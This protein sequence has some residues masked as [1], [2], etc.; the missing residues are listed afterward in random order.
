[1]KQIWIKY[2]GYLLSFFMAVSL[3][4][5]I[6]DVPPTTASEEPPALSQEVSAPERNVT[7]PVSKIGSSGEMK[8]EPNVSD[9]QPV[10]TVTPEVTREAGSLNE[11]TPLPSPLAEPERTVSTIQTT[12][13][14][15]AS[16]PITTPLPSMGKPLTPEIAAPAL[17]SK[18]VQKSD[19]QEKKEQE[20]A[21][22]TLPEPP[23]VESEQKIEA[24]AQ[25]AE[26][27]KETKKTEKPAPFEEEGIDTLEQDGGNWLLKRQALEKT[28]DVIEKIKDLFTK[29]LESRIEYLVKRNKTDRSFDLF[30]NSIGFELGDLNQLLVTLVTK[31]KTERKEEGDLSEEER[32]ALAEVETKIA[33]LKSLK[34]SIKSITD[35][36]ASLDDAIMQLEKEINTSNSYQTRA[37]RNFQTIKKVLS[38]EKAEELYL[39]TES[40]LKNMQDIYSY[41]KGDLLTYF[42]GIITNLKQE[43]SQAEEAIKTLQ[44]K[45]I[46]LKDEVKKI[47]KAE[48]LARKK[49]LGKTEEEKTKEALEKEAAAKKSEVKKAGWFDPLFS[50]WDYIMSFFVTQKIE[51]R[52]P[53]TSVDAERVE[54]K[55]AKTLK[56]VEESKKK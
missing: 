56:E 7:Q 55:K 3:Y 19:S 42:N 33:E 35:M 20:H 44:T 14:V 13:V 37:W 12:P 30:A 53:Q 34:A 18:P 16:Q 8:T 39:Q 46:N 45:G 40:L 17:A 54:E 15:Q 38:D 11:T 31:L 47:H 32:Q 24:T 10:Q 9:A 6:E 23:V 50:A 27:Q 28:M 25:S 43:M 21:V 52:K 22:D 5:Q 2:C 4:A 48:K 26:A 41:L 51:V 36:D 49:K 29:I 1:M